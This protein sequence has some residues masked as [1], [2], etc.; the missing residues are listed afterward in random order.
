MYG[1][2]Y[3]GKKIFEFCKMGLVST[4]P[5]PNQFLNSEI[6]KVTPSPN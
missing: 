1:G 3:F 5:S 2:W 6:E 4:T